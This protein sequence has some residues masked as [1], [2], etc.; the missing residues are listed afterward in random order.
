MSNDF[1][2]VGLVDAHG[3]HGVVHVP[4]ES[5]RLDRAGALV[6]TMGDADVDRIAARIAKII[7]EPTDTKALLWAAWE[8]A[9]ACS[10]EV[11]DAESRDAFEAWLK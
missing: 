6:V 4:R 9:R 1:P 7:A 3:L 11:H 10:D 5:L 8:A 2:R